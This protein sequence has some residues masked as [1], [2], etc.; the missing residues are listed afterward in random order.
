MTRLPHLKFAGERK[1]SRLGEGYR[2]LA[3][4]ATL[5]H[6]NIV[7]LLAA[8]LETP[9]EPKL[10][11]ELCSGGTLEMV[12][13]R[14]QERGL[15]EHRAR[16]YA[17][18]LAEALAYLHGQRPAVIHRDVKPSN[19][20]IDDSGCVKLADF[21]L[22][23]LFP[24]ASSNDMYAMTG[25]TGTLRWMAPEVFREEPYS[26]K[27]D[28]F[29]WAMVVW[30]M[31]KGAPPYSFKDVREL[32]RIHT[33]THARPSKLRFSSAKMRHAV[34]AAWAEDAGARPRAEDLVV[35]L[36]E[37]LKPPRTTK[38]FFPSGCTCEAAGHVSPRRPTPESPSRVVP[39]G[40]RPASPMGS[41]DGSTAPTPLQRTTAAMANPHDDEPSTPLADWVQTEVQVAPDSPSR[42]PPQRLRPRHS[43]RAPACALM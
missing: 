28:V 35:A 40:A 9:T 20:L 15:S 7:R 39:L 24:G 16:T 22:G 41:A 29:S 23:R 42:P 18:Q 1:E 4:L 38:S 8:S 2:E 13:R 33:K 30:Y 14:R 36:R 12:M 31:I 34:E 11:L 6:P 32:R 21:G 27:V 43:A 10:V 19:I 26:L 37:P 25:T 3:L 5:R 17:L